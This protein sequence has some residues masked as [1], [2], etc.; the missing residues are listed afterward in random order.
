MKKPNLA[1]VFPLA[2]IGIQYLIF[3]DNSLRFWLPIIGTAIIYG[4]LLAFK[5]RYPNVLSDKKGFYIIISFLP[6]CFGVSQLMLNQQASMTAKQATTST[7]SVTSTDHSYRTCVQ[8]LTKASLEEINSQ[9][10]EDRFYL[11]YIGRESCPFCRDF[12][13]RLADAIQVTKAKVYYLDTEHKSKAL[14]E[15]ADRFHIHSIPKLLVLRQGKLIKAF[16]NTNTDD[17]ALI[18]FLEAYQNDSTLAAS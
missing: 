5:H 11:L 14:H 6:I 18:S 16:D 4:I 7:R 2:P 1:Y 3:W 10:S 8:S 15:F 12:C 9:S 17:K 13:P